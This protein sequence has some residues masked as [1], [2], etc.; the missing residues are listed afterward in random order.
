MNWI[1]EPDPFA[2]AT[3]LCDGYCFIVFCCSKTVL[4]QPCDGYC[5][6]TLECMKFG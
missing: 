5:G 2:D 3:A 6:I 4:W 1:R